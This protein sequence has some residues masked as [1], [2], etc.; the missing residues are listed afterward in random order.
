MEEK[1]PSIYHMGGCKYGLETNSE[2][3]KAILSER[4]ER[5]G[6]GRDWR[7][8]GGGGGHWD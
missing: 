7:G 3:G 6:R 5:E 2:D 4:E 1:N 8:R